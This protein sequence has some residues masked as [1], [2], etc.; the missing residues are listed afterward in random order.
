MIQGFCV[1][2][3]L[4]YVGGDVVNVLALRQVMV[5]GSDE[6]FFV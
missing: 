1:F 6:S 3:L 5:L 2:R 4:L